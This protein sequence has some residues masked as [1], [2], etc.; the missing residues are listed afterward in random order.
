MNRFS[1]C[2]AWRPEHGRRSMH[3][4]RAVVKVGLSR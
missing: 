1:L 2:A 4:A 3:R